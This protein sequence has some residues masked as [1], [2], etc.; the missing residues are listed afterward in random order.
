MKKRR[1]VLIYTVRALFYMSL[2]FQAMASPNIIE[3]GLGATLVCPFNIINGPKSI[4]NVVVACFEAPDTA[5]NTAPIG[6]AAWGGRGGTPTLGNGSH[7]LF[8]E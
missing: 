3:Q 6:N 1:R 8:I 4:G 2:T 5:C 7:T